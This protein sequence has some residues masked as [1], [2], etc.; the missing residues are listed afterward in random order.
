SGPN[1]I[2]I[3]SVGGLVVLAGVLAQILKRKQ[4]TAKEV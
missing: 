2:L 1:W 4:P 3:G